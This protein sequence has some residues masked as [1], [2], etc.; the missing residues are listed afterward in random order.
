MIYDN[1]ELKVPYD[2]YVSVNKSIIDADIFIETKNQPLNP[3]DFKNCVVIFFIVNKYG[4]RNY[5]KYDYYESF[6]NSELDKLDFGKYS[7]YGFYVFFK[8][9]DFLEDFIKTNHLI[10]P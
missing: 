4:V 6:S 5:F 10:I 2:S 8:G 3:F 7:P 9:T 1:K